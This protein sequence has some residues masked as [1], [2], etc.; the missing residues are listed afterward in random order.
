MVFLGC[1]VREIIGVEA[2]LPEFTPRPSLLLGRLT[3]KDRAAQLMRAL[4]REGTKKRRLL[5]CHTSVELDM[6]CNGVNLK[7]TPRLTL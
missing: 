1:P 4:R 6:L 5:P 7:C 2:H 3:F